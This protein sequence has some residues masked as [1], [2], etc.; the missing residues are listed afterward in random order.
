ME[1][2]AETLAKTQLVIDA[3]LHRTK[4]ETVDINLY[5]TK[6]KENDANKKLC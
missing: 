1:R 2:H 6:R 5:K 3:T 4:L